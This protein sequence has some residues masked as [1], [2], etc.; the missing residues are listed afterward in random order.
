MR[1]RKRQ[2]IFQSVQAAGDGSGF[3]ALAAGKAEVAD[4]L[5]L[6]VQR[7]AVQSLDAALFQLGAEFG[8]PAG[9]D[10]IEVLGKTHFAQGHKGRERHPYGGLSLGR[11]GF[12]K[13]ELRLIGP[14]RRKED[15]IGAVAGKGVADS[16]QGPSPERGNVFTGKRYTGERGNELQVILR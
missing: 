4:E 6:V 10:V 9:R 16:L 12:G 13:P 11:N 2:R 5:I 7:K 15:A 3:G 8:I 1:K 14:P